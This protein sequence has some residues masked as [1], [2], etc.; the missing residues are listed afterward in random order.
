MTRNEKIL[1]FLNIS[2]VLIVVVLCICNYFFGIHEN[3]KFN[4]SYKITSAEN[5]CILDENGTKRLIADL[6]YTLNVKKGESYTF[7][8]DIPENIPDNYAIML[9]TNTCGVELSVDGDVIGSYGLD[10]AS[11]YS[12]LVGSIKVITN[13]PKEYEGRT[14]TIKYYSYYTS[15]FSFSEFKYG[16]EDSLKLSVIYSNLWRLSASAI[17]LTVCFVCLGISIS[18]RLKNAPTTYWAF[19]HLGLFMFYIQAWIICSSDIPQLYTNANQTVSLVSFFALALIPIHYAAF[20]TELLDNKRNA[21]EVVQF[22]GWGVLIIE[23]F[24]LL[25]RLYDLPNVVVLDHVLLL[26][27][28]ILTLFVA[29]G[30]YKKGINK[31]HSL[32]FAGADLLLGITLVAAIALFYEDPTGA[33]ASYITC[34]G[35]LIF[36]VL[37]FIIILDRELSHYKDLQVIDIYRELAYTDMLTR[38]FN[39]TAFNEQLEVMDAKESYGISYSL[40]ILDLNYLKKVNDTLGHYAG[41]T[42][43]KHAADCLEMAFNKIGVSYRIGGDEFAVILKNTPD[44]AIENALSS[45]TQYA[46]DFNK[47]HPD[48]TLSFSYGYATKVSGEEPIATELFHKADKR[49]YKNKKQFHKSVGGRY[50]D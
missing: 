47:E 23:L 24:G 28:T 25:T 6:P 31:K 45:L 42:V 33:K 27:I 39:R 29:F 26:T 32:F 35:V 41:D 11:A 36:S 4:K 38:I 14:L 10:P 15:S 20:C 19:Y 48:L 43:I 21:F 50:E 1:K 3:T 17:F 40:V 9:S 18:R 37:L 8:M 2:V 46:N 7:I 30:N 5:I 49:M 16:L 34:V 44:E 22:L 13:I 12:N